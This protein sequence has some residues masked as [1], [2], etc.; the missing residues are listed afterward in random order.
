[1][2]ST[3]AGVDLSAPLELQCGRCGGGGTVGVP[4]RSMTRERLERAVAVE[5]AG[6]DWPEIEC[7]ACRGIGFIPTEQGKALLRFVRRFVDPE[8]GVR[9]T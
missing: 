4:M 3:P 9:I 1:M 7:E 6:G 8:G 2:R 5:R